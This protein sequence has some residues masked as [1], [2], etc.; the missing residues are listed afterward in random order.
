M[1]GGRGRSLLL[2]GVFF[3]CCGFAFKLDYFII[4]GTF[5]LFAIVFSLP[6]FDASLNIEDLK[7]ERVLESK[8]MF[9]DSFL[10]VK[11]R[12]KNLG[13]KQFNFIDIF[14]DYNSDTFRLVVGENYIST[15]INPHQTI[16][17]SYILEPKVRGKYDI[18]P[19]TVIVRDRLG[20]NSEERIVPNSIDTITIYPPYE[21]IKK[22][23]SMA[24]QRAINRSFGIHRS[25][26]KGIG[27]EFYGMRRYVYGD[28]FRSIDWKASVRAQKLIVKEFETERSINV[29]IMVDASESMGGG[30]IENTKFEY[31]IRAA[32]LCSKISLEQK[33][34]VGAVTFSD[35]KHLRF[36]AP[37]STSA[38]FFR[39]VDFFGSV[40]PKHEKRFLES[41]EELS[42]QY[43]KRSL[44]I[45]ISDLET[46][47]NSEDILLG[48]KKLRTYGH[49]ILIIAPFSP[50]FE[51]HELELSPA[52]KAIAEAI[53]EEMM[54]HLVELKPK[55]ESFGVPIIFVGP[56]DFLNVVLAE[57]AKARK[58]GKGET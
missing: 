33:D 49:N 26:I 19:I 21:V 51:A 50:W 35:K 16:I 34:N 4:F 58:A 5:C 20:F 3:L 52:D 7:V 22:I 53:A 41:C 45:I 23:E 28:Q 27:N 38:H 2:F 6:Q 11:V 29:L 12:V 1:L 44:I 32:M 37:H 56:D 36:L 8:T 17:F 30:E 10:H 15:R 39:L 13:G 25:R 46:E 9:K 54:E 55:L 42:R 18:G 57:F 31:A 43:T 48:V 40:M 24:Q 47:G 14:D